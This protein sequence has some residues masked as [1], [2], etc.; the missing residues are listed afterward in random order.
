M[1][2]RIA[3]RKQIMDNWIIPDNIDTTGFDFS[4]EP[5]PNEPPFVYQFRSE[6]HT[7]EL[8]SH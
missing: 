5:N 8:Q 2:D 3:T 4:F 7:S 6:E 1:H